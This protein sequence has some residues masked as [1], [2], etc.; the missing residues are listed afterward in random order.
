MPKAA[1]EVK[2]GERSLPLVGQPWA[3]ILHEFGAIYD[4]IREDGGELDTDHLD[5][6]GIVGFLGKYAYD[7]LE[8][9]IPKLSDYDMPRWRFL[10][11]RSRDAMDAGDYSR[12]DDK[13]PSFPQIIE[14]FEAAFATNGG[15]RLI[16]MLGKVIE[17]EILRAETSLALSEWR[18]RQSGSPNSPGTSGTSVTT[19]SGTPEET[20]ANGEPETA[21]GRATGSLLP[22]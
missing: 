21:N 12:A 8:V 3:A 20:S 10:G 19:T 5:A 6:A 15:Q 13:S 11:Y 4:R 7:A 1:A 17:P 2:L 16:G 22:A 9:F 18:E 14:A